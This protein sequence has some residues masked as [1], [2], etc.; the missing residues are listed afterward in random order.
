MYKHSKG[1]STVELLAVLV[2]ISIIAAIATQNFGFILS[3]ARM[4]T[5]IMEL[6]TDIRHAQ[7]VA[8][9][10]RIN[11]YI[12]FDNSNKFYSIRVDANPL[13]KTI[14]WVNFDR[15]IDISTN[16]PEN[17][18]HFT[19]LGAPSTGGTIYIKNSKDSGG[20]TYRITILPATG[21]IR[22]YY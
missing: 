1:F 8:V 4:N 9:G 16:F 3:N 14:K 22:V 20:R 2:I 6:V 13:P 10:E 5:T 7:Q 15:R 17:R 18:F 12:I 11:C 19:S 21:R